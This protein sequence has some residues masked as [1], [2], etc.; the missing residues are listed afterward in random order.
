MNFT[1]TLV[2]SGIVGFL[3][4]I[5]GGILLQKGLQRR[6]LDLK[7]I[8]DYENSLLETDIAAAINKAELKQT[9][10]GRQLLALLNDD[11][12]IPHVIK[13]QKMFYRPNKNHLAL[14]YSD[15]FGHKKL[16]KIVAENERV[17]LGPQQ[18]THQF[19]AKEINL[20]PRTAHVS[21]FDVF[22]TECIPLEV[23]MKI[24]YRFDPRNT[25]QDTFFQTLENSSK[26]IEEIISTNLEKIIRNDIFNQ[27]KLESVFSHT[28]KRKIQ[29]TVSFRISEHLKSFGISISPSFGVSIINIQTDK[30]YMKT[31]EETTKDAQNKAERIL[32]TTV[33]ANMNS[34]SPDFYTKIAEAI[35]N[36]PEQV[37]SSY[38]EKHL[39]SEESLY[40]NVRNVLKQ[41]EKI[42]KENDLLSKG[43]APITE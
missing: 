12:E 27:K 36:M 34:E 25:S 1:T 17:F 2:V 7:N 11:N 26:D 20:G 37:T 5:L 16:K 35:S 40:D 42:A 13:T 8:V 41:L 39:G 43:D 19:V 10:A 6:V 22:T 23:E 9:N 31:Q 18:L 28:E 4:T 3:F 32:I 14:I 21:L 30:E 38:D 24:F 33:L 29:E 15:W